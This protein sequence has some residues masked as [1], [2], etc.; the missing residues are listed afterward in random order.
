MDLVFLVW[1]FSVWWWKVAHQ[2]VYQSS[3]GSTR[4]GT[5]TLLFLLFINNL[6]D[7][8]NSRTWLLA[9]YCIVYRP[10]RNQEDCTVLQQ[11]LHALAEWETKWGMAF[12]P[13]NCCVPSLSRSHSP[14]GFPYRHEGHILELKDSTNYLRVD[15][16]SSFAWKIHINRIPKKANSMLGF[17][18][19]NL[20]SCSEE[21]KASAYFSMVRKNLEYFSLVCNP[22][23]KEQIQ[24]LEMIQQRAAC[25][26]TNLYRYISSISSVL[27]YLQWKSLRV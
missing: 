14:N 3:A 27:E 23:H 6:P 17:L 26:A 10:V 7:R 21:T 20:G 1:P 19:W 24:N 15:L 22:H 8:I 18:R 12:H 5:G 13:Q 25:Y 9:H 4:F 2:T 16:Q 11:D